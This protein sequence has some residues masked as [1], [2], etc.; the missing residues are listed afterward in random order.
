MA[1]AT[2]KGCP[3][4]HP[5]RSP[6]SPRCS[7]IRWIPSSAS[8][9]S[10]RCRPG[11]PTS[12][13]RGSRRRSRG[14]SRDASAPRVRIAAGSTADPL[15]A[16]EPAMASASPRVR[17]ERKHASTVERFGAG[18]SGRAGC[19]P[20]V[21]R[22]PG[23][24]IRSF[25]RV[26]RGTDVPPITW[27]ALRHVHVTHLLA[28]GAAPRRNGTGRSRHG[29]VHV[30][31]VRPC[32]AVPAG[33]LRR[34]VRRCRP[35]TAQWIEHRLPVPTFR[36]DPTKPVPPRVGHPFRYPAC[37]MRKHHGMVH[38]GQRWCPRQ[39]SNLRHPV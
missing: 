25:A 16:L 7:A 35:G 17:P 11:T 5:V 15:G 1:F 20:G 37:R 19:R 39:E 18:A 26:V 14:S 23:V 32:D 36:R 6:P 21:R 8:I 13:T 27:H 31:A 22:S 28:A 12:G 2:G 33:R 29:W 3:S 38:A 24:L 34:S 10:V 30:A 4:T 9:S